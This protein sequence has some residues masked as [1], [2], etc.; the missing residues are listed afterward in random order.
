MSIIPL[1]WLPDWLVLIMFVLCALGVLAYLFDREDQK[2]QENAHE[3]RNL[4]SRLSADDWEHFLKLDRPFGGSN[5]DVLRRLREFVGMA[6]EFKTLAA[7]L[8]YED[9][10]QFAEQDA[11]AWNSQKSDKPVSTEFLLA[12]NVRLRKFLFRKDDMLKEYAAS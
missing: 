8:S 11:W 3:F 5:E 12:R 4:Q 2:E 6:E 9:L 10:Q 7:H 1:W